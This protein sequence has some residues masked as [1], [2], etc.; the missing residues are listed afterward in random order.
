MKPAAVLHV[1]QPFLHNAQGPGFR[2]DL[3][4]A[5]RE[6][7]DALI[8][9]LTDVVGIDSHCIGLLVLTSR[10]LPKGFHLVVV[11]P[12]GQVRRALETSHVHRLL[13]MADTVE[14]AR[15]M[16]AVRHPASAKA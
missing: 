6:A 1:T 3:L 13:A 8:L 14:R 2:G 11:T 16:L 9:D 15:E 4:A 12:G 7:G 5:S 10:L